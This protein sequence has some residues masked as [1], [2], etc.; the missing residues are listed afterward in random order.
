LGYFGATFTS[1]MAFLK[2]S[3][4]TTER[5]AERKWSI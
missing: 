5:D 4:T 2:N 1:T 3:Q